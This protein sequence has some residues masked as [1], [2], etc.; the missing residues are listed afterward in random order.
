MRAG[1]IPTRRLPIPLS[2]RKHAPLEISNQL[3]A[4]TAPM[5]ISTTSRVLTVMLLA[6]ASMALWG[7]V[8]TKAKKDG[9][10]VLNRHFQTIAT[11]G[12]DAAPADYGTQFFRN[13]TKDVDGSVLTF[14]TLQ[15]V[16]TP[17]GSAPW[18]ASSELS[19]PVRFT[20]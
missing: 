17:P 9:Q 13:A 18:H 3:P 8:F 10:T 2:A 4:I 7:C 6:I 16:E 14:Y 1:A 20:T 19:I 15:S 11:N 5:R 12:F